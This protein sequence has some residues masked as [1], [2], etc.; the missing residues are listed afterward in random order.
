MVSIIKLN[1]QVI[2][3]ACDYNEV[4]H[5]DSALHIAL[6]VFSWWMLHI[7]YSV[8]ELEKIQF[9]D[10][11]FPRMW[12]FLQIFSVNQIVPSVWNILGSTNKHVPLL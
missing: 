11:G 12:I 8:L 7:L 6:L 9:G 1:L 2:V 5:V 10:S 4:I 3:L